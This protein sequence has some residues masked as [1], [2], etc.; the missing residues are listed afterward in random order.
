MLTWKICMKSHVH[1]IPCFT[2]GR[3]EYDLFLTFAIS[4]GKNDTIL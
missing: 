4:V 1:L 3:A 2:Q